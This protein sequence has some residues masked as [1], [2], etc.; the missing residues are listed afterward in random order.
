MIEALADQPP[1]G[2]HDTRG[3][4]QIPARHSLAHAGA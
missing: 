1:G 3:L 4:R 2:E